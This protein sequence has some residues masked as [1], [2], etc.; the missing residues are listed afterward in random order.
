[1][2]NVLCSDGPKAIKIID[3]SI[4]DL[5]MNLWSKKK[6]NFFPAPLPTS[7]ELKH[8]DKLN[9]YVVSIKSNGYRFIQIFH[10]NNIYFIDRKLELY[11]IHNTNI[12]I[13]SSYIFDG[14]L[15]FTDNVWKYV[16]YDC[17]LYNSTNILHE[18]LIIRYDKI[19]SFIE[20]Y[21]HF[22]NNL[23]FSIETKKIFKFSKN[24]VE[25]LLNYINNNNNIDGLIFTPINE[26]VG[27]Y[28]QYT[29]YKWKPYHLHTIDFKIKETFTDYLY[30]IYGDKL[31]TSIL[32][33]SN[34]GIII[35]DILTKLNF[36]NENIVECKFNETHNFFEPILI[37]NDKIHPNNEYTLNKTILNLQENIKFNLIIEYMNKYN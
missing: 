5:F 20:L 22:F 35:K 26:P 17:Y 7:I 6:N 13:P 16:I 1:M 29:L 2:E 11:T 31:F 23:E 21:Q 3:Q 9:N 25:S 32:K 37:R 33:K 12:Q 15:L 8:L 34:I 36:T 10:N 14:E 4:I 24:S 18:N 27:Q 28:T 19:I 30:L